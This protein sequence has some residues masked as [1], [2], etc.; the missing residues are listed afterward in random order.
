MNKVFTLKDL[1]FIATESRS[2][3]LKAKYCGI[4]CAAITSSKMSLSVLLAVL[5]EI[6]A[7]T[8]T[9]STVVHLA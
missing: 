5:H 6:K 4:F 3:S 2:T 7:E 8:E 1:V 9:H